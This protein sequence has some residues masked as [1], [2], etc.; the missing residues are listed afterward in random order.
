MRMTSSLLFNIA[1]LSYFAAT[2]IFFAFLAS[3][4][5]TIGLAGTIASGFGFLVQTGAFFL[6]WK[7]SYDMGRGH[8]PLSNLY[9]SVVFFAWTIVLIF[10]H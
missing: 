4:N 8:A 9:E 3:K 1:T 6:R 7:E 10:P 5:R 2:V